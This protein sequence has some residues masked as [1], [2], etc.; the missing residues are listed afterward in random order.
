MPCT[1]GTKDWKFLFCPYITH[2]CSTAMSTVQY[3]IK[4]IIAGFFNIIP[5]WEHLDMHIVIFMFNRTL[6]V[7]NFSWSHYVLKCK[8]MWQPCTVYIFL[9]VCWKVINDCNLK[10]LY[11]ARLQIYVQMSYRKFFCMLTIANFV[12]VSTFLRISNKYKKSLPKFH[13]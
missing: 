13:V 9:P 8:R 5:K 10:F 6:K 12:A 2:Y 1:Y 7:C 4:H 3:N 11:A